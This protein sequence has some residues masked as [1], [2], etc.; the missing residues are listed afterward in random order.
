[1]TPLSIQLVKGSA[2]F[3]VASTPNNAPTLLVKANWNEPFGSILAPVKVG[4]VGTGTLILTTLLALGMPLTKTVASAWPGW[5]LFT[6][7][8]ANE[9]VDQF[10]EDRKTVCPLSM[11]RNCTT[12]KSPG[13]S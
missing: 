6:A 1:M 8:D 4:T 11:L 12:R 2:R 5:K 3:V 9:F 10:R 13:D 7:V